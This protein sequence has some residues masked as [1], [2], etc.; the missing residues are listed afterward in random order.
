MSKQVR[1]ATATLDPALVR[2][3]L[4]AVGTQF[5]TVEFLKKDGTPRTYNGLLRATSRLV[6]S[7][8]GKA[9]G[10]AMKER[11]QVW[12]AVAGGGSKSFFLDRVTAIR[13]KGAEIDARV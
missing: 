12:L 3:L 5:V 4:D 7:E 9:Q 8:R 1:N 11:G 10:A 2:M 6:G 13:C